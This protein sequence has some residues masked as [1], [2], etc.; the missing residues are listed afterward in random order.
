M[1]QAGLRTSVRAATAK[2]AAAKARLTTRRQEP[3]HDDGMGKRQ[4][5]LSDHRRS[6][7]AFDP[8]VCLSCAPQDPHNA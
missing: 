2:P 3:A 1:M 6:S 8:I 7:A 5:A 4:L